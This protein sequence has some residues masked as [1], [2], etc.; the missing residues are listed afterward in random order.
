MSDVRRAIEQALYDLRMYGQTGNRLFFDSAR[1]ALES[2]LAEPEP[3]Q[4][5]PVFWT[6][7]SWIDEVKRGRNGTFVNQPFAGFDVPLYTYPPRREPL[8][9]EAIMVLEQT[10]YVE[11]TKPVQSKD[12][13]G[14]ERVEYVPTKYFNMFKFARAIEQ[15]HDIGEKT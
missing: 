8:T 5:E 7:R 6:C 4:S 3:E 14:D 9:P 12:W 13:C 15:A 2:A 1:S 10:A 11:A